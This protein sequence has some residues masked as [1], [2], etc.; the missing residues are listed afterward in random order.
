[1]QNR[2]KR[3]LS[4]TLQ[5]VLPTRL[6]QML[7]L[8]LSCLLPDRPFCIFNIFCIY[9]E[10]YNILFLNR[11]L[12]ILR[13]VTELQPVSCSLKTFLVCLQCL[14][15]GCDLK[16]FHDIPTFPTVSQFAKI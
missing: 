9:D 5:R 14:I 15:F 16:K 7:V 3:V 8:I 12:L 4:K 10:Q 11:F 13:S 2:R 6:P 1:M